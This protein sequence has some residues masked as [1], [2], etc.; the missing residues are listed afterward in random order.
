MQLFIAQL[1]NGISGGAIYGLVAIGLALIYGT[2]QKLHFAHGEVLMFAAFAA[3]LQTQWL[4]IPYL[5]AIPL[6]MV[7][8]GAL[9]MAVERIV[10]RPLQNADPLQSLVAALGSS[11]FLQYAAV[12]IFTGRAQTLASPLTDR[13]FS[14]G[15]V[16]VSYQRLL[17]I[18]VAAVVTA[19]TYLIL[20]RSRIGK[21]VRATVQD[22]QAARALG[23]DVN[24]IGSLVFL[25]GSL[26]AGLAGVLITPLA[27][28]DPFV[29]V[30]IS[31]KAFIA[32]ILGG[33][34]SVLGTMAAALLLG[35]V[36]AFATSFLS[37]STRDL[38]TFSFLLLV[39]LVRP[40]G[41]FGR[42]AQVAR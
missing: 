17:I 14:I 40:T 3:I 13:T 21:V 38:V 11:F 35:L 24:R 34:G 33:F 28:V 4:G 39:L 36:E 26:L 20:Q 6:A 42:R 16:A 1:I 23:I 41:L 2:M 32:V 9:G 18:V 10:F 27:Y 7:V 29:G 15:L 30:A 25:A 31:L 19:G 5:L 8:A 37:L 22:P 12:A